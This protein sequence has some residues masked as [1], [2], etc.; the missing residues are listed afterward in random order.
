MAGVR[1]Y[2]VL[3]SNI[4]NYYITV[5]QLVTQKRRR[6]WKNLI[7]IVK[8]QQLWGRRIG[9]NVQNFPLRYLFGIV[10]NMLVVSVNNRKP[11]NCLCKFNKM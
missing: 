3:L 4:L 10:K 1:T 2:D 5:L 6:K 8:M 9:N 7:H 11:Q